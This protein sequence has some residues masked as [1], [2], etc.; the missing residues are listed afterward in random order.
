[1]HEVQYQERRL[2]SG[3]DYNDSH[4]PLEDLDQHHNKARHPPTT[5]DIITSSPGKK[6][7][8]LFYYQNKIWIRLIMLRIAQSGIIKDWCNNHD[9]SGSRAH[10][11]ACY[12]WQDW[13]LMLVVYDK[14]VGLL[15]LNEIMKLVQSCW[16]SPVNAW[17]LFPF[18][19]TI[20]ARR[21]FTANAFVVFSIEGYVS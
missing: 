13:L 11:L 4:C 20:T 3:T 16:Y 12:C 21:A 19:G 15:W 9:S 7:T 6:L 8:S 17:E 14:L 10:L 18:Y 5:T 1:M 2:A